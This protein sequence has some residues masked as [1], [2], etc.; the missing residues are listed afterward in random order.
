MDKNK[1]K[2]EIQLNKII[3]PSL[4]DTGYAVGLSTVFDNINNNFNVLANRD[5]VKGENGDSLSTRVVYFTN[6]DGTLNEFGEKLK[7]CIINASSENDRQSIYDNYSNE[8]SLWDFFDKNP[9][10]LYMLFGK[11]PDVNNTIEEPLTSLYYIFLDGRFVTD[12]S[13]YIDRDQYNDIKDLSCVVIYDYTINGFKILSNAYPTMYYEPL[14]GLCWKINGV[15]TG[16]PIQGVEGR[17]GLNTPIHIVKCNSLSFKNDILYG[18]IDAIYS[19]IDG[20]LPITDGDIQKY[21]TY[22]NNTCLIITPNVEGKNGNSIYFGTI[23]ELNNNLYCYCSQDV[24]INDVIRIE[25]FNSAMKNITISNGSTHVKGL[26]V[27]ITNENEN[28]QSVH[29]LSSIPSSDNIYNYTDNRN[30]VI[31]SPISNI[32]TIDYSNTKIDRYLYIRVNKN[33]RLFNESSTNNDI[34]LNIESK[35]GISR[36][37]YILKYKFVDKV[38]GLKYNDGN[39]EV[40]NP[41]FNTGNKGSRYFT[42]DGIIYNERNI[43]LHE[44]NVLYNTKDMTQSYDHW[45]SIPKEFENQLNTNHGVYR[46]ELCDIKHEWD[47]K[48]M[49]DNERDS[50]YYYNDDT[51]DR[52]DELI[53]TLRVLFTTNINPISDTKIMWFNAVCLDARI[54]NGVIDNKYV[55]PGWNYN[56]YK[57]LFSIIDFKAVYNSDHMSNTDNSLNINYDINV[58]GDVSDIKRNINVSGNVKSDSLLTKSMFINNDIYEFSL[59]YNEE[60]NGLEL[61]YKKFDSKM[62]TLQIEDIFKLIE[63]VKVIKEKLDIEVE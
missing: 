7:D 33:S 17:P 48:S 12:K 21:E 18:K 40:I 28:K 19:Y 15:E 30:E 26:F 6:E 42:V 38:N 45:T 25:D 20:Y 24:A 9:G 61:R 37:D 11:N 8:I 4:N 10:Q 62:Q 27:P 57:D 59:G 44:N 53:K 47:P 1:S 32:N 49:Y 2:N 31:L 22:I 60:S 5:F 52:S 3:S 43:R 34:K 35:L 23:Q 39:N 13:A 58:S 50:K 36:Y 14:T 46:W 55:I 29:L 63:D 16:I 41:N 54:N 56:M 51:S